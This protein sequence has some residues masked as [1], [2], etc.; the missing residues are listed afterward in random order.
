MNTHP[1][2][3]IKMHPESWIWTI[4][5]ENSRSQEAASC[6]PSKMVTLQLEIDGDRW[7]PAREVF[8][9]SKFA[10]NQTSFQPSQLF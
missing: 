7:E 1:N 10:I 9:T 5:S 6:K 2:A 3:L 8:T 4:A